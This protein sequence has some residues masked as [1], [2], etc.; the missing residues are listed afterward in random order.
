MISK[1]KTNYIISL[2]EDNGYINPTRVIE[3]ARNPNSPLHTEF[4]WDDVTAA[5][6]HRLETARGLIRFVKLSVQINSVT[7]VAPYYVPDPE[8]PQHSRRYVELTVAGRNNE[9]ARQVLIAEL[10]RI[11]AAIRRAQQIAHVLGLSDEL[12]QLLDNVTSI[13]TV[14]ERRQEE[15]ELQRAA[16]VARGKRKPRRGESRSRA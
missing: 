15:K 1:E 14:T 8:R 6:Q 11:A 5:H 10:D 9:V 4:D 3:D 7:V 13:K 16:K 12:D 2:A